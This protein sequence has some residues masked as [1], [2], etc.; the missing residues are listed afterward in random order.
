V[1]LLNATVSRINSDLLLYKEAALQAE[2]RLARSD[3]AN[4]E[5]LR[6][7]AELVRKTSKLEHLSEV[8]RSQ[9]KV[10]SLSQNLE[11]QLIT[12]I[13]GV[14]HQVDEAFEITSSVA[15]GA[16]AVFTQLERSLELRG[17]DLAGLERSKKEMSGSRL[18]LWHVV[19]KV[20]TALEDKRKQ[21]CD[22]KKQRSQRILT[23]MTTPEPKGRPSIP[24]TPV[25]METLHNVKR[26]LSEHLSPLKQSVVG[27]LDVEYFQKVI[28]SLEHHIDILLDDLQSAR[29]ALSTKQQLFL[30]LEQVASHHEWEKSRLEKQL[31][32]QRAEVQELQDTLQRQ[33][34][35]KRTSEQELDGVRAQ[36][37]ALQEAHQQGSASS[38]DGNETD[39]HGDIM[40]PTM[41]SELQQRQVA[42]QLTH[43][44]DESRLKLAKLK[45]QRRRR[46]TEPS[47]DRIAE[48][49]ETT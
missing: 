39:L 18:S 10:L 34:A 46:S 25:V 20:L 36:L 15:P 3:S 49:Y 45:Q 26:V 37:R 19:Q 40:Q 42:L 41:D 35:L 23:I 22:W 21:L 4:E 9:Q 47:L 33:A 7:E 16:H 28:H 44:L 30:D 8:F 38:F 24:D 48:G 11:E 6:L 13:E 29:E 14:I 1:K 31:Q 32:K 12:F 2:F 43:H 17:L 5:K 27:R